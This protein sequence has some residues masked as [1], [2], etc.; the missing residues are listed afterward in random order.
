MFDALVTDDIGL[1]WV[2]EHEAPGAEGPRHWI[3]FDA[4]GR[5][6]GTVQMPRR[7]EVFQIGPDFVLGGARDDLDIEHIRLYELVRS[8]D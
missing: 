2:R 4:D 3:V 8:P 5:L 1:L 7:F 6:L